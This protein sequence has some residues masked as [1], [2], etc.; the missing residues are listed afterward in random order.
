MLTL[1]ISAVKASDR[2]FLA[3]AFASKAVSSVEDRSRNMVHYVD[4]SV[5]CLSTGFPDTDWAEASIKT[6]LRGR[7]L[8]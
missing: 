6:V 7:Q 4:C 8:S 5:K 1:E 3:A 2:I